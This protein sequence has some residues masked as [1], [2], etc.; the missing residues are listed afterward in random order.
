MLHAPR[1]ARALPAALVVVLAPTLGAQPR[2]TIAQFLNPPEAME[3]TS[4]RSA[5]RV[6]WVTYERGM[7]NVYTA[8]APD[9]KPVR[10]T[11][12]TKDD[13]TDLTSV[14]LSDDGS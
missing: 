2:P 6:A 7:R 3:I 9:F 11:A 10:V 13:G 1:L 4:A 8:A 14:E 12:F 5:D